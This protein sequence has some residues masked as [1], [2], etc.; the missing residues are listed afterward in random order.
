MAIDISPTARGVLALIVVLL[1]VGIWLF[2]SGALLTLVFILAVLA[3][4][5][6]LLWAIGLRITRRL[7]GM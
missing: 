6:Y 2:S 4:A 7:A 1:A 3:L 5:A